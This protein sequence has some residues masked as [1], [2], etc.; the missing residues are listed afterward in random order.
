[1]SALAKI[2]DFITG[3]SIV[4][5]V[6]VVVAIL[7][8]RFAGGAGASAHAALFFGTL[9]LTFVAAAFERAR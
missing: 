2:Y 4:A 6:G 5:P 9:L 7:V 1:M 3:G 8:A